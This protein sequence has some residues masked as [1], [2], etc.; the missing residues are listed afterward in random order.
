MADGIAAW[1]L[2]LDHIRP[3]I[4]QLLRAHRPQHHRRQVQHPHAV[5][6][7]CHCDSSVLGRVARGKGGQE[8]LLFVNKKK[9]KNFIR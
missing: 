6:W 9:Q 7:S 3:G 5:Q 4:A 2:H 1:R 8:G